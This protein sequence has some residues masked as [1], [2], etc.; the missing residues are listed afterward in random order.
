MYDVLDEASHLVARRQA[1]YRVV[2]SD[3]YFMA[4]RCGD[5]ET[6]EQIWCEASTKKDSSLIALLFT[7]LAAIS[8]RSLRVLV[9]RTPCGFCFVL[10]R[11]HICSAN[12]R[13]YRT[14]PQTVS[15]F[16]RATKSGRCISSNAC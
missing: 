1:H 15:R 11:Q 8:S 14:V 3:F 4:L 5:Q 9:K 6:V 7:R 13:A 12:C 16:P 2:I 10:D